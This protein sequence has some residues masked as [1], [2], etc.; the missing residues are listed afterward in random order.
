MA[1]RAYQDFVLLPFWNLGNDPDQ[2]VDNIVRLPRLCGDELCGQWI[3]VRSC[4]AE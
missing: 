2:V 4:P 1:W 3:R